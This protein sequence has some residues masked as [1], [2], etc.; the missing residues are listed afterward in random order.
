LGDAPAWLR[1]DANRQRGEFVLLLSASK[2]TIGD[3]A[4]EGERVLRLLI[5]EG[6]PIKQA[7]KLAS[8]I[9]GA[10][11]KALYERALALR[12]EAAS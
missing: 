9:S 12:N 8:A 7:T 11:R 4:D 10:G 1:E 3:E 6:L 5:G 2:T